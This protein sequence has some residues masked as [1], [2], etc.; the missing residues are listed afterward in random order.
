MV[1]AISAAQKGASV[2]I[3]EAN[4]QLG[5]KILASGNGR[6]NISNRSVTIH[7]FTGH[8][9]QFARWVLQQYDFNITRKFFENLGLLWSVKED[10]RAYPLSN[11]ARSVV[12]ILSTAAQESGVIVHTN[13]PVT[14]LTKEK[15]FCVHTQSQQQD[16]FDKLLIATGLGAA[17]QLGSS[18]IGL[19]FAQ[20]FGHTVLPTFAA[21]VQ[22]ELD[23]SVHAK[24]SGNKHHAKVTLI[25]DKERVTEVEGDILFT[26]YGISG[27]AILD[28]STQAAQALLYGQDVVIELNMMPG[29]ERQALSTLLE[30]HAKMHPNFSVLSLLGGIVSLRLAKVLLEESHIAVETTGAQLDIKMI[31]ALVSKLMQWRFKVIADHGLKHAEASGGGVLTD[32]VDPRTMESKIITDLHFSGEV[33]DIVGRRGGYNFQFAWASGLAAAAA[34]V[35]KRE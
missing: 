21:L 9:P 5:K 8:N 17:P 24:L 20:Q 7:D 22:L 12:E 1:A 3:F 25:V 33:L 31:K 11:E 14:A 19:N 13:T 16:G 34:M 28:V 18:E 23:S 26:R 30:R 15:K 35:Q 6:C 10:G 29:Y 4:D 27:F 32:E 2:T